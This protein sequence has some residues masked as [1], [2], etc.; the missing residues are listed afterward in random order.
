RPVFHGR[1]SQRSEFTVR[2][3]D[4]NPT[5]WLRIVATAFQFTDCFVLALGRV[6]KLFIY[7]RRFLPFVG[8]NPLYSQCLGVKRVSEHPLQGFHLVMSAF[9]LSLYNTRLKLSDIGFALGPVHT[10]PSQIP[11]VSRRTRCLSFVHLL[12]SF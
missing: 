6:P 3:L 2:F 9:F 7:S 4:V 12:S 10:V 1:Y 11:V 5:E 8:S